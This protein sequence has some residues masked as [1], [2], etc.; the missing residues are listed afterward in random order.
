MDESV[1]LSCK[2]RACGVRGSTE[3]SD[4]TGKGRQD[5]RS[6]FYVSMCFHGCKAVDYQLY[7]TF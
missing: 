2:L 3:G 7:R 5:F 1:L 6:M 4:A